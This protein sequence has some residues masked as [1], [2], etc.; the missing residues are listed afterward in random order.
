MVDEAP[1]SP[2]WT[3]IQ[4]KLWCS[5]PSAHLVRVQRV[6]NQKL[7]TAF[8]GPVAEFRDAGGYIRVDHN[9]SGVR[10]VH[11]SSARHLTTI[12]PCIMALRFTIFFV[13]THLS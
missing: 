4:A 5:L 3:R 8:A 6:Q 1:G 9:S 7:W 12:L 10:E 13:Y 2:E 11:S